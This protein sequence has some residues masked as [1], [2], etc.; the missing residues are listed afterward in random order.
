MC[1]STSTHPPPTVYYKPIL[2]VYEYEYLPYFSS[3][4]ICGVPVVRLRVRITAGGG[5]YIADRDVL[6]NVKL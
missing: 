1:T 3:Y 2:H 6:E 4:Y 5:V